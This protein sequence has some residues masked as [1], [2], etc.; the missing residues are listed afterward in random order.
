M[1]CALATT[2]LGNIMKIIVIIFLGFLLISCTEETTKIVEVETEKNKLFLEIF[3]G[4]NYILT[5]SGLELSL[6]FNGKLLTESNTSIDYL[7][8]ATDT[9]W[10]SDINISSGQWYGS[11]WNGY[12]YKEFKNLE[13]YFIQ[14][15]TSGNFKLHTDLGSL[16]G[17]IN[18][19]DSI[20][21]LKF[22]RI[23]GNQIDS[24]AIGDTINYGEKLKVEFADVADF[25]RIEYAVH[26]DSG[27][28]DF[29][30]DQIEDNFLLLD[31]NK[32]NVN[33]TI[34]MRI[35]ES[36]NGPFPE[37]GNIGNMVGQGSGYLYSIRKELYYPNII[38]IRKN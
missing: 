27:L 26:P 7:I 29:Y 10:A 19:P 1:G 18:I 35:I 28:S 24:I 17:E 2:S 22:I 38:Y 16:E 37:A 23:N 3:I 8:F 5:N 36:V 9:V 6:I 31:T 21:N 34:Q 20:G 11:P 4:Q 33:G 12:V 15:I 13:D 30:Y 32:L 25:F 14:P